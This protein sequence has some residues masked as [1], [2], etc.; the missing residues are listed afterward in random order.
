[1]KTVSQTSAMTSKVKVARLPI[2]QERN[3]LETPKLIERLNTPVAIMPTSFQVEGKVHRSTNVE[4]GSVSYLT[5][6][7]AYELLT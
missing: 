6:G 7:N 2:S 1:M 4:T 3:V 5:N